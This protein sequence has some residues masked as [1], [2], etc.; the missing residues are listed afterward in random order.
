MLACACPPAAECGPDE[1]PAVFWTKLL[2]D[3]KLPR[4]KML[5]GA[6]SEWAAAAG[7]APARCA[8]LCHAGPG[9]WEIKHRWGAL[10]SPKNSRTTARV[11]VQMLDAERPACCACCAADE[12]LERDMF[13]LIWGP[14]LAGVSAWLFCSGS[15]LPAT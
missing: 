5:A 8:V 10:G 2:H 15:V 12:A 7:W 11:L 13:S 14:T 6:Q 9:K 4:G 1:L 3:S